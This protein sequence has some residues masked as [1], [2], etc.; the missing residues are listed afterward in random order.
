MT[1][2]DMINLARG[3]DTS[4][5]FERSRQPL[6]THIRNYFNQ[7]TND[8]FVVSDENISSLADRLYSDIFIDV[9]GLHI[10]LSQFDLSDNRIDFAKSFEKLIKHHLRVMLKHVFDAKYDTENQDPNEPTWSAVLFK[11]FHNLVNQLV[12]LSR[13]CLKNAD[14]QFTVVVTQKLRQAVI[15]QN[16]SNNSMFYG[17]FENF[18]RTQVQQTLANINLPRS[19][20]EEFILYKE[21]TQTAT[22]TAS[23][24]SNNLSQ[25]NNT[26]NQ[27]AKSTDSSKSYETASSTL[28]GNFMDIDNESKENSKKT[29]VKS[30]E[31]KDSSSKNGKEG[32][33]KNIVPSDWVPIIE[34]DL[35]TQKNQ[36]STIRPFSDAY[37]SGMPAKRRRILSSKNEFLSVNSFKKVLGRTLEKVQLKPN[38]SHEQLIEDSI[39][40]SQLIDSFNTEFDAVITDRLRNDPDFNAIIKK[41]SKEQN[42]QQERFSYSK[43]RFS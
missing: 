11:N 13:I 39:D 30:K 16:I 1:L 4:R 12:T 8:Q 23:S 41:E 40:H 6:R 36:Q 31:T 22:A 37:C 10:D 24:S 5:V 27:D 25:L 42:D 26:D 33:W 2:G 7:N 29:N 15:S 3:Q 20:I 9:N 38:V 34:K 43:K 14:S 35:V 21:Q 32:E 28:S 17:I 18:V 19:S